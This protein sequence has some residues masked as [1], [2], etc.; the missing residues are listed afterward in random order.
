[1]DNLIRLYGLN[2]IATSV[3]RRDPQ[4]G[5]KI[6]KLRK[7]YEG[8]I[9]QFQLSGRNKAVTTPGEF[10]DL[11]QYPDEEWHIQKE[12][13]HDIS[14]GLPSATLAKLER[15]MQNIPMKTSGA[16]WEE[17]KSIIGTDEQRGGIKPGMAASQADSAAAK[18]KHMQGGAVQ[19]SQSAGN[20][21]SAASPLPPRPARP[22]RAGTK[23]R[24]NNS[25]FEGY[26]EGYGDDDLGDSGDDDG[27]NGAKKRRRKVRRRR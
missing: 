27:R 18:N 23:R 24:Y 7:S 15:A 21:S 4:T 9:K 1:M 11:V 10:M 2:P 22:E 8:Q 19:Q 3:A 14:K 6:N 5:A 16:P 26:G 12:M 17:W 25:S 20:R 13:G